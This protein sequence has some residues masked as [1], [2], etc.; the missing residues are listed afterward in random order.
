MIAFV[1][2]FQCGV[3]GGLDTYA[4]TVEFQMAEILQLLNRLGRNI[5]DAGEHPE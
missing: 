2:P 3:V 4:D 1:H 5:R